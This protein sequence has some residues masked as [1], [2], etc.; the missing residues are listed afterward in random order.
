M[1]RRGLITLASFIAIAAFCGTFWIEVTRGHLDHA[2]WLIV[3]GVV[4]LLAG[5][6]LLAILT[7]GRR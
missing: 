2:C 3:G 4:F 7:W 6:A 1:S 5:A